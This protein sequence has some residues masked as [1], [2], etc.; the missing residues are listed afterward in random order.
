[1]I[2]L[3][4]KIDWLSSNSLLKC[5]SRFSTNKNLSMIAIF[6]QKYNKSSE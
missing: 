3:Q 6:S 1:M 2:K 5:E 4:H